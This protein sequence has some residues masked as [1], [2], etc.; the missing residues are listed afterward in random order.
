MIID[1]Y[2]EY[3]RKYKE[4]YGEKCIVLM[5]VGSFYEI[6]TV[7][8][9]KIDNEVYIIAE[10]CGI[11]TSRKNKTI[12]EVSHS[13]PVMAGFPL[14]SVSKFTQI[15]LNNNYTIVIVEQV[16]EPPNIVREVTEILSPG[17]IINIT[18]KKSNYMMVIFYEMISGYL[19]AGICG[20]DLSTGKTFVYEVGSTQKDPEFAN[21]EVFRF[22]ST[23]NPIEIIIL[24]TPLKDDEKKYIMNNLNINKILT[25][26]KWDKCNFIEFFNNTINQTE[27]L[28]KA[29]FIKQGLI[30]I[31][32]ILNME[33]LTVAR[34]AFCCLLQFA[35]EHNSDIIKELQEPEIFES[36]NY[37]TIEYNS[38]VQ[39]NI[40]G[41]YQNDKPLIDLLNRCV[42]AFG[43]RYFKDIL[44]VPMTNIANINKSYDDIDVLLE[45]NK[46][47][48]I[49]KKLAN[50]VDIE[51]V[52]RRMILNKIAPQD[53]LSFNESLESALK[54]YG[55][56]GNFGDSVDSITETDI[57]K[58]ISSYSNIIDLDKASKYNLTDKNNMG[59]IFKTGVFTEIDKLVRNI[60]ES[61]DVIQKY[62]DD[63]CK[64]G[65]GTTG[66]S[67]ATQ[68]KIDSNDREGYFIIITKKRF[69]TANKLDKKYMS[70]F[71]TKSIGTSTNYKITNKDIEEQSNNIISY[72]EKLSGIVAKEY[73]CFV[74][75]FI[76]TNGQII[77][78][79]IKYLVRV[80]IAANSA[81]NAI[82]YCYTRPVIDVHKTQQN[83]AFVDIKNMRHPLIERIQDDIE[84]VGN[85][86][87]LN[88]DGVL[89]YGINA[90]GKSSFMKAVGINI[91]MAQAGMFVA[92]QE[93][94]YY[95]Y[96]SIF[97]RISGM[98]NI[99]KG[100][101]S[102]TVEMTELR[103]ILQRCNKFSLV[104][105]DEICC[106]TESIS[107]ISIV[108]S[109][110]DTLV[111]KG[112]SF[113]FA[114]HLHELTKISC[115]CEHIDNKKL[116]VK[117]IRIY[118][119]ENNR[120]IYDRKIQDG[121]G[122]KIYGIEVCKSL[123]MPLDFMKNAEKFR[124]EVE[125]IKDVLVTNKKSRY[126]KKV[127][128]DE[129][130]ICGKVAEET[131]HIIYQEN[132]DSNGNIIAY[133]KN[134]KHNLVPLCKECH[135]KEHSGKLKIKGY[136]KTSSGTILDYSI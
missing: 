69:E 127:I 65:S 19:I 62:C 51:R 71:K 43:S 29:F 39:L 45:N 102:F 118:I 130:K 40:L 123:D 36:N 23:Y 73:R 1:E 77:D 27:I 84:Y 52:K 93:M 112:P 79:L 13:N 59:N 66:N 37:M 108:A 99:Y 136:V 116:F 55:N 61:Y 25:H 6:Y 126:N 74:E 128:V 63:I 111:K 104:I 72:N 10:L 107:G 44:L 49:R 31:I 46:Y 135:K 5:Q 88:E 41:L 119:D 109:G 124:K 28:N 42:T 48:D 82:E 76:K 15:L 9:N 94:S 132:A 95:P 11:Q 96:R 21:D 54:I 89:L 122:S 35:Y 114:S 125:G 83:S 98:D 8:D 115:I 16:T 101:S 24:S 97:T 85:D 53:W 121:Q 56:L 103:N 78:K 105:G 32:E 129:C 75:N 34:L 90:S 3:T 70:V 20:I 100:M 26:Y 106:G 4:N 22:I 113:I 68:C 2:L 30:S 64:I 81:K 7:T 60:Q 57:V 12:A 110:I 120:I 50:I 86:I 17:S 80:D 14:H 133:H 38:A 58:V 134:K 91:I 87:I 92:A 47:I 18:S 117:H 33:R 67:D 131:H